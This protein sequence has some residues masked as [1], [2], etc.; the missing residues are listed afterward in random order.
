[1]GK[2]QTCNGGGV[3]LLYLTAFAFPSP[4]LTGLAECFWKILGTSCLES[5]IYSASDEH[6]N[7]SATVPPYIRLIFQVYEFAQDNKL[8]LQTFADAY[9]TMLRN[10][11]PHVNILKDV[12]MDTEDTEFSGDVDEVLAFEDR[13]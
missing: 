12:V 6:F 13:K 5:G 3:P 7:H 2:K 9:T 11:K 8:W 1:V 4:F 10:T